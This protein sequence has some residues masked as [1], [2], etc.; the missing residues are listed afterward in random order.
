MPTLLVRGKLSEIVS[1]EGA[2]EL[3]ELIPTAELVDVENAGHMVAGDK[4]DIF[5]TAIETFLG[6]IIDAECD[7]RR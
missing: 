2:S 1:P 4:N 5:D 3:L 7:R 6:G